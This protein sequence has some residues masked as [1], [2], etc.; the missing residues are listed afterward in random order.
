LELV[1]EGT[2]I[3]SDGLNHFVFVVPIENV[4]LVAGD[5]HGLVEEIR[6][7]GIIFPFGLRHDDFADGH[8]GLFHSD[9]ECIDIVVEIRESDIHVIE[10]RLIID[11]R[12]SDNILFVL[13][14]VAVEIPDDFVVAESEILE[15][16]A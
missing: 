14:A 7:N 9:G 1:R 6:R 11:E 12:G 8:V 13:R 3:V 15:Y 4:E 2:V 5:I 10:F 16:R